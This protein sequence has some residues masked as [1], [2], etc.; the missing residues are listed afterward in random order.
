MPGL[1][2]KPVVDLDIVVSGPEELP[3]LI[4]G[5]AALGYEH[6]GE[7]GVEGREAFRLVEAVGPG[8]PRA[9]RHNLYACPEGSLGLR[10]HRLLRERL[11]ADPE[12]RDAY[13]GLKRRLAAAH[14]DSID[15]YCAGKTRFIL[16][17]LETSLA[18][19]ELE[20]VRAANED[21]G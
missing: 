20:R 10:N 13:A 5:L 6:R 16:G 9:V 4:V 18:P 15:A 21:S 8:D 11:R 14:P 2:A 12:L 3:G 19:D 17:V 1:A 7:L